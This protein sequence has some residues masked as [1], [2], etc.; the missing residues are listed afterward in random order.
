MLQHT[1]DRSDRI[2]AAERRVTIIARAHAEEAGPHLLSGSPGQVVLQ[3]ANRETA[4]GIFLGLA[5][6]R[7]QDPNASVVIFP[8]DHFIHPE[9]QFVQAARILARAAQ[10]MKHWI[11]LLGVAPD[12]PEPEYGYIQPGPPLGW[13]ACVCEPWSPSW[14]SRAWNRV[15]Q[16]MAPASCGIRWLWA[17][18]LTPSGA[19]AGA[20]F[21]R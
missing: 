14:K 10:Q 4:A 5:Q 19:W 17:A 2:I 13:M 12:R 7:A 18:G 9:E 1:L 6:I 20:A 16:C 15:K 3:P 21:P 11:F 8:S